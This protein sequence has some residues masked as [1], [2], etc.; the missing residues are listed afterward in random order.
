MKTFPE[1]QK[2]I[3][4]H[5][6]ELHNRFGITKLSVFGSIVRGE[7]HEGSDVDILAEFDRPVSLFDLV[8]A[9]NYLIDLLEMDVDL[10]PRRSVRHELKDR[11]FS[12]AVAV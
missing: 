3:H 6:G 9:E 2:I 5:A 10:I 8:G 1:I 11:I 4:A 7:A 12:E